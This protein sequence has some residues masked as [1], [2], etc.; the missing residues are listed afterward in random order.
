MGVLRGTAASERKAMTIPPPR[1][2]LAINHQHTALPGPNGRQE[3]VEYAGLGTSAPQP[4]S[5]PAR[6]AVNVHTASCP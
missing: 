1:P 3:P 2:R 6:P 4:A 5:G